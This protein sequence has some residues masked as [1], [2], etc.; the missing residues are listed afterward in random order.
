MAFF[1]PIARLPLRITRV[2]QSGDWRVVY[3]CRIYVYIWL[4]TSESFASLT[5]P[6]WWRAG[7]RPIISSPDVGT[8]RPYRFCH[9]DRLPVCLYVCALCSSNQSVGLCSACTVRDCSLDCSGTCM[10]GLGVLLC[11]GGVVPSVCVPQCELMMSLIWCVC[12]CL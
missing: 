5:G 8:C 4:V 3:M 7:S 12:V 1:L 10:L 6:W 11:R 9:L 2:G